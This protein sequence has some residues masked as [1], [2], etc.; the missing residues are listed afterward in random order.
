MKTAELFET[1]STDDVL[2]GFDPFEVISTGTKNDD[3]SVNVT[4]NPLDI[5][6]GGGGKV[7][8]AE[9]IAKAAEEKVQKELQAQQLIEDFE[10]GKN[11]TKTDID[12]DDDD[13]DDEEGSGN[14]DDNND[15][16]DNEEPDEKQ[17]L[18]AYYNLMVD[19]GMWK[20][21]E[22]EFDGSEEHFA[23]LM[24]T[25][26]AKEVEDGIDDYLENA[27]EKNP[28]GANLGKRLL[29]H[30]ATGGKIRDFVDDNKD[31]D[32]DENDFDNEDD[33]IAT[34]A[35]SSFL[36]TYYQSLGWSDEN[37][38]RTI[39]SKK[40]KGTIIDEAK[41]SIE[42]YKK[43]AEAKSLERIK[44]QAVEKQKQQERINLYRK[45]ISETLEKDT[46][47]GLPIGKTKEAKT[48]LRN[49]ILEPIDT[50]NGSKATQLQLDL[51]SVQGDTDWSVALA[52]TLQ[53]F[54]NKK[55]SAAT[56]PASKT[57]LSQKVKDIMKSKSKNASSSSSDT[58][59]VQG[60]K[61]NL[62]TAWEI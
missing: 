46:V 42:P 60:K 48:S 10:N 38:N 28:D 49:Y 40:A 30:L 3:G 51:K 25:N 22:K 2:A 11:S 35:A 31:A 1:A 16:L 24:Q 37:I 18:I 12:A 15:D 44:L 14:A 7:K 34:E 19:N 59:G 53:Q 20:P 57:S 55:K 54:K 9:D 45:G 23:E 39:A 27:F 36:R 61:Q 52:L 50:D 56:T 43:T 17:A 13:D 58:L 33:T 8:S 29:Q 5:I 32:F 47:I 21:S 6:N 62:R 4:T 26:R 41:D